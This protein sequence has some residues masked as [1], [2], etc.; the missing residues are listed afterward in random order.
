MIERVRRD[1]PS[2]YLRVMASV[3]RPAGEPEVED[4]FASMTVEELKAE[5]TAGLVTLF[6]EF[7]VVPAKQPALIAG[8]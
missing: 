3:V 5:L 8:T 1:D 4:P 6:P 7:R 2:T